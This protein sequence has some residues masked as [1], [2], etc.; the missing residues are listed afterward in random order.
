MN[1]YWKNNSFKNYANYAF[2]NPDFQEGLKELLNLNKDLTIAIMCAE[3]LWWR[4][5]RR[6][7]TDYLINKKFDVYH[8]INHNSVKK[9]EIN[10]NAIINKNRINYQ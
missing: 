7:I 4:C 5:H 1:S 9:A 3:L 8:I 6:I 10:K 2:A